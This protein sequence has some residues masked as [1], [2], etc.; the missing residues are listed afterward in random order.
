MLLAS[1]PALADVS[2]GCKCSGLPLTGVAFALPILAF[3][4]LLARR[5]SS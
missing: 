1:A 5:V 4:G 2:P 3:G